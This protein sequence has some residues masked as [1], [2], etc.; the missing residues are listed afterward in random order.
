VSGE[1][2]HSGH[3][4]LSFKGALLI[5]FFVPW[6]WFAAIQTHDLTQP[7]QPISLPVSVTTVGEGLSSQGVARLILTDGHER[8]TATC[9]DACDD[10]KIEGADNLYGAYGIELLDARSACL[11][12]PRPKPRTQ[13][14][15]VVTTLADGALVMRVRPNR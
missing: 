1:I 6:V 5:G 8:I 4:L 15:W 7:A 3:W 13:D 2:P 10:L 14:G 12:C 9:R 11:S